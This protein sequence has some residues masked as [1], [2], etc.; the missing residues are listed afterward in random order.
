MDSA[1]EA[2]RAE[3]EARWAMQQ[4][5][6]ERQAY[7]ALVAERRGKVAAERLVA[8]VRRLW[9]EKGQAVLFGS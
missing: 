3:C 6:Q 1:S 2:W 4:A 5:K 8:D 7:Y 9:S